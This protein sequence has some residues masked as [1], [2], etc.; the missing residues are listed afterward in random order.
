MNKLLLIVFLMITSVTFAQDVDSFI[1]LLRSDLKTEKKA[2]ITE[3]MDFTEQ[4]ASAFWPEYRNYEFDLEKLGDA[5]VVLI[6]DYAENFEKMTD[7]KAAELIDKAF[8]FREERLKLEK[9]Y[10]KKFSKILTPVKAAK[11]VQLENQIMLMID[12]QISAE[13]PLVEKPEV[14]EQK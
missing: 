9:K 5:R 1:E 7:D 12:L 14:S 6:K 2:I 13:L 8:D 4:E 10:F 11:W 3:G